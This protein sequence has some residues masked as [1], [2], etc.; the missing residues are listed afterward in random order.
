MKQRSINPILPGGTEGAFIAP[1]HEQAPPPPLS[2]L[3]CNTWH[4]KA[5]GKR[6]IWSH[7]FF[8]Y[9]ESPLTYSH[10]FAPFFHL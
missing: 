8:C 4:L 7:G 9:V 5:L 10:I 1:E 2:I 3:V 6:K